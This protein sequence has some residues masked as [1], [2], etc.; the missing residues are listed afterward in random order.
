MPSVA[1]KQSKS[2]LAVEQKHRELQQ[3]F[4]DSNQDVK[5]LLRL[6]L[7]QLVPSLS[8]ELELQDEGTAR[9]RAFLEDH[10][11]LFRFYRR[12]RYDHHQALAL[13]TTSIAWRI[14]TD[15]DLLSIASLHP[16]YVSPP[17]PQPP[18]FWANSSFKDRF[19]RPCGVI[20]LRCVER[21][22]QNTL[23]ELK[24][25][26]VACME[27]MRRYIA[28]LNARHRHEKA[29]ASRTAGPADGQHPVIQA[30]IAVD[31]QGS[32][33]ANLELELLP[34]LL[35]LLKNHF[36]GMVGAVYILHYGWVHAGMWAVAK[37]VLPEQ[38]LARIFFPSHDELRDHFDPAHIPAAFSGDL[39]VEMDA[40]SNDVLRK[41]G[42]P[43]RSLSSASE[44]P[45]PLSSPDVTRAQRGL[46]RNSS[47]ESMYEV[48]YSAA[49]TPWASRPITPKHSGP[50]TPR[51]DQSP[52]PSGLRMTPSAARKLRRLQMTRG[53]HLARQRSAS[54]L[55][56]EDP[57]ALGLTVNTAG[58]S[59]V[60]TP[61]GGR[62]PAVHGS[63]RTAEARHVHFGS[64]SSRRSMSPVRRIGMSRGFNLHSAEDGDDQEASESESDASGKDGAKPP[65]DPSQAA[66]GGEDADQGGLLS[67]W[68]KG[69]RAS[70]SRAEEESKDQADDEDCA[71]GVTTITYIDPG[72]P[73]LQVPLLG[74]PPISRSA[75]PQHRFLSQ[76]S[77]QY[78]GRAGHVSP[79]NATN[80]FFG[81][82]AYISAPSQE[83]A[84]PGDAQRF[85]LGLSTTPQ[86]LHARRRKRDLMRTLTYLFVLRLL[87]LHREIR[88][89]L[90]VVWKELARTLSVAGEDQTDGDMLWRLAEERRRAQRQATSGK[91]QQSHSRLSRLLRSKLVLYVIVIASLLRPSWRAHLLAQASNITSLVPVRAG[92]G[93]DKL[94]ARPSNTTVVVHR[95]VLPTP[96]THSWTGLHIREKLGVKSAAGGNPGGRGTRS[97]N[98]ALAA[99]GGALALASL[100][101]Y[102]YRQMGKPGGG[103]GDDDDDGSR[104]EPDPS[105]DRNVAKALSKNVKRPT[106][107]LSL[108]PSFDRSDP[109]AL[110]G[111]RTLLAALAPSYLV[112]LIV[113]SHG[114]E[115]LE[116][117]VSSLAASLGEMTGFDARRILEYSRHGGRWAIPRA[118][119]CDCHLEILVQADADDAAAGAFED[120]AAEDSALALTELDRIRRSSGLV[121]VAALSQR[122]GGGAGAIGAEIDAIF[123]GLRQ[124]AAEQ[125]GASARLDAPAGMRAYDRRH[126]GGEAWQMVAEQVQLLRE[127]WK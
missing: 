82:P 124:R 48:F 110:E 100:G 94:E 29:G 3:K 22:E 5:H 122:A 103:G 64:P 7:E 65:A 95:T 63:R 99:A 126:E 90:I 106:M 47:Y 13:L 55:R 113:P 11:T 78:E 96:A 121:V 86:H 119:A 8:E 18:L 12:S 58:L 49:G 81:Y 35:D 33:M 89:K 105:G 52:R 36:P 59:P 70:Q 102:L 66:A 117:S 23:D 97:R 51:G 42:R 21:T 57:A 107:S 72:S 30:V 91:V 54:D 68:R 101:L 67:R 69:R 87:A 1:Q 116:R 40:A 73:Q 15:L 77:R 88:W 83:T 25:Y 37:R 93:S 44:Q 46:S 120:E 61:Y 80:P 75:V 43:K 34:F 112:H 50:P 4:K 24:E 118:L 104:R 27:I 60:T 92:K 114:D 127:S 111:L 16:L 17:A 53:E 108:S 62:S 38:A 45:T 20:S 74:E 31:L 10:A 109:A 26:I 79:Y 76:R 2:A 125:G 98:R 84:V 41:W 123:A 14:K 19:G 9:V 32:G 6:A 71:G 39:A 85:S 115:E 56:V 28:D